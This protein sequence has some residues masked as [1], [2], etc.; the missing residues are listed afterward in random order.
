MKNWNLSNKK[1]CVTTMLSWLCLVAN[2]QISTK[3]SYGISVNPSLTGSYNYSNSDAMANAGQTYKSYAD[4]VTTKESWHVTYGASLWISY[5]FNKN[6]RFQGGIGYVNVGHQR[7]LSNLNI[8]DKTYPGIGTGTG[9]GK[10]IDNTN[11]KRDMSLNYRYQYLQIPLLVNFETKRTRDFKYTFHVSTGLGLNVLLKHNIQA[12]LSDGYT[13]E[14]QK[15]FFIDSTGYSALPVTLNL[16]LGGRMDYRYTKQVT[17]FAQ[18]LLSFYPVP[19]ATGTL[20]AM[21]WAATLNLGLT[22]TFVVD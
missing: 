17:L 20:V 13:I 21:P 5:Q 3:V 1:L 22:Y 4:S 8:G 10:I 14:G 11:L 16:F 7:K 9:N 12:V 6:I 15:E 18:P 2:A 19:A